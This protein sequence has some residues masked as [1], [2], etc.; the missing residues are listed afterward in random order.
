[1]ASDSA[2]W[3]TQQALAARE[4]TLSSRRDEVLQLT[5]QHGN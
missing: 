1:M 2:G 3:D 5:K 4:V